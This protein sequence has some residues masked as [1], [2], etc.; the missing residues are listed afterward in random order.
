[1]KRT[2]FSR[3]D[4]LKSGGALIVS[5]AFGAAA[6]AQNPP[7][8]GGSRSVPFDLDSFLAIHADGTVTIFTSRVDPGTGITAVYRQLAAEELGIPVERF[9]VV[10]GDTAVT[11]NHG[12]T[13]GSQGVPRGGADIRRAAATAR[14]AL[15]RM[16]ATQLNHEVSDLTLADSEVRPARGGEGISIARLIGDKRFG[17][18]VDAN[19]PL[20]SPATFQVIGKPVARTDVPGKATGRHVYVQDFSIAGMAHGRVIRPP[21][22]GANLLSVDETSIQGI[23]AVRAIRIQNFLGVVADDEWAAVRAARELKTHWSEGQS[24]FQTEGLDRTMATA[25]TL[26]EQTDIDRGDA[27]ARPA[28]AKELSASYYWPFHGHVS[29]AP[30]CAVADVKESGT[31]V[32][33]ST[34]DTW[35]LRNLIAN[36]FGA[37]QEKV[38]VV[39]LDGSGSYGSNGAFDCAADAVLLSRAA[40]RPVRLQWMRQDEHGWDPKGPAQLLELRAG[41]DDS[42][43]LLSWESRAAGAPGPQWTEGLLGPLAAGMSAPPP[44]AGGV[45]TTQNLDPPYAV[46]RLRVTSRALANT[47]I[48]LSNLRA[49]NKIGNVFA[50]ESFVDELAAAAGLDPVA[51][52]RAG[53]KDPR[54]LAVLDRAAEMIGWEPRKAPRSRQGAET[55]MIGRGMAYMRYKQAENYVAMA[56]EV[57]VDRPTGKITVRRIVCAH[58]CGLIINPDGLRNQVEGNILHTLSRTLHEEVVFRDSRVATTDWASYPILRFPEAPRVEVA[59]IDHPDQPSY[60]AGEAACAPVAAAL[61]NAV[62]DATGVRLRKAPFTPANFLAAAGVG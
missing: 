18:K 3:R 12:G 31:T 40:G 32:W 34:Q 15:L 17:I 49:P 16:G 19:A 59:L 29:L 25:P 41:L 8:P 48:R 20:K 53:L 55:L 24:R 61:G 11:P 5:F 47:P 7:Q 28:P 10:Q 43:K 30:S 54:A 50:V 35:G 6:S 23:P 56:M 42:G 1:M 44:R 38:R 13:G 46:S 9:T 52:R 4:L 58:D 37:P 26:R 39:Y 14:Q 57:A 33:S 62:Y 21:A 22:I 36:T 2:A 45:P 51:F 27:S 60:G